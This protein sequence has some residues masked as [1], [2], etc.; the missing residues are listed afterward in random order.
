MSACVRGFTLLEL[1]LVIAVLGVFTALAVPSLIDN[2]ALQERSAQAQLRG[3]LIFARQLALAQ[4][5]EVCA[6][7]SPTRVRLVY[8]AASNCSAGTPVNAPAGNCAT[9][10]AAC[11]YEVLAPSRSRFSGPDLRFNTRGQPVPNQTQFISVGSLSLS[12]Q[13]ETGMPL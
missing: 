9:P 6:Q 7:V 5:R 3:M 13:A 2:N 1:V 11:P 8:V 4:Q 12:I 10:V